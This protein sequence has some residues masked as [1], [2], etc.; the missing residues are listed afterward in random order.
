MRL[1]EQYYVVYRICHSYLSWA[2]K[3]SK[4]EA[5]D[6]VRLY[7]SY[8]ITIQLFFICGTIVAFIFY[9]EDVFSAAPWYFPL[10]ISLSIFAITYYFVLPYLQNKFLE[11]DQKYKDRKI[12]TLL[13]IFLLVFHVI[14]VP[15]IL[16]A[17]NIIGNP[18]IVE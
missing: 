9:Q 5:D 6:L 17:I 18:S 3:L 14:L 13:G 16:A 12:S 4:A 8:L 11:L 2:R 1:I 15:I 7:F 10:V